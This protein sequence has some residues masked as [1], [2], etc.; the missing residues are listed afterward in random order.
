MYC[1]HTHTHTH[2][3]VAGKASSAVKF[4]LRD[5]EHTI[6]VATK[7][8]AEITSH[9]TKQ[10]LP[11]LPHKSKSHEAVGEILVEFH[12]SESRPSDLASPTSSHTSSQEDLLHAK[13]AGIRERLSIHKRSPSLTK[14]RVINKPSTDPPP[15]LPSQHIERRS[16][17]DYELHAKRSLRSTY[18]ETNIR[19]EVSLRRKLSVGEIHASS[20]GSPGASPRR[21][22]LEN[23]LMP[24]VTGIS[25]REGPVAGGQRVVLRGSCLGE[26]RRDVV[27]VVLAGVDCTESLEYHS[28]SEIQHVHV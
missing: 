21:G 6:G 14:A 3:N 8:I 28:P 16:G 7:S 5:K 27:K 10:W 23:P 17:S 13:P 25:P 24:Q 22:S 19:G 1:T 9:K 26:S 20:H 11:L 12:V 15:S 2:S 4:K 18:S